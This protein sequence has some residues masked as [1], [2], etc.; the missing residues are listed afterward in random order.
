MRR[1]E[2][3]V[4]DSVRLTTEYVASKNAKQ[5]EQSFEQ[6][7]GYLSG[8]LASFRR[9][10][11]PALTSGTDKFGDLRNEVQT[12]VQNVLTPREIT[13]L[14]RFANKAGTRSFDEGTVDAV[15]VAFGG[16]APPSSR[17][18]CPEA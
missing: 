2:Q 3:A 4:G 6:L 12:Y 1:V 18:R 9:G 16:G 7:T 13:L 10:G 17:P 5:K 14:Q 15:T 11:R 8:S